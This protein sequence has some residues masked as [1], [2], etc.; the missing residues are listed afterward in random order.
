MN[1]AF[2]VEEHWDKWLVRTSPWVVHREQLAEAGIAVE[3]FDD[4]RNAWRPFDAMIL[5]VWL[6]WLNPALF[7]PHRIIPVMEKFS[8]YRAAFPETTQIILNHTD[9]GRRAYAAPYWRMGDPILFRNPAYDRSELAPFPADQI[10]A[11]E[12]ICGEEFQPSP[13]KYAAGFVG[14]PTGPEGYRSRVAAATAA[15][16][17]GK[18][19]SE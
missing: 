2:V 8:A 3:L 9:M 16:G 14:T 12:Y 11:Y 10:F 19:V 6:D 7:K 4:L 18:C 13:I 17:I 15:V 1:V 5:M